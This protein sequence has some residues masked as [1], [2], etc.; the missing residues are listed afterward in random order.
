MKKDDIS[1]VIGNLN[2]RFI[3]EAEQYNTKGLSRKSAKNLFVKSPLVACL[4]LCLIFGM[5]VYASGELFNW[6]S[7]ILFE[8]GNYIT[9]AEKAAFKN[10]SKN[11]P[12]TDENEL[13][14]M[15]YDKAESV[16]G[17]ELLDY[18]NMSSDSLYYS[19]EQNEDGSIGRIDLWCA[20]F[21]KENNKYMTLSVSMLN[22][23]ADKGFILAFEE[24]LDAAGKKELK[25]I[26]HNELLGT[27]M[28]VY[29]DGSHE[30]KINVSFVY[31]DIF[32]HFSGFDF[33]EEEIL[34]IVSQMK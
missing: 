21:I 10:I 7:G 18:E 11:A 2:T 8:D 14:E 4:L 20:D 9:V 30:N 12:K 25:K 17:V 1:E 13:I 3:E 24:G 5:A 34:D 16:L 15:K 22:R 6:S 19:T 26:V 27:E 31:D 32:Y 23:G 29:T 28:I 33:T